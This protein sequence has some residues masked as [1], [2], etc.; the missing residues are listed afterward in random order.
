MHLDGFAIKKILEGFERERI[1]ELRLLS[2][3]WCAAI[4]RHIFSVYFVGEDVGSIQRGI[5]YR[6][7]G[8]QVQT[9]VVSG[10]IS[11][12]MEQLVRRAPAR[13]NCQQVICSVDEQ[14]QVSRL[15]EAFRSFKLLRHLTIHVLADLDF[16]LLGLFL[17][18]LT[19]YTTDDNKLLN[20]ISQF[21]S[22]YLKTFQTR[23][24]AVS[25][26]LLNTIQNNF[27]AL[28]TLTILDR[29]HLGTILVYDAKRC[30]I[31]HMGGL[32]LSFDI[33]A[34]VS[35]WPKKFKHTVFVKK[36]NQSMF[37]H[38][39]FAKATLDSLLRGRFE[40]N[41]FKEIMKVRISTT[42]ITFSGNDSVWRCL[43]HVADISISCPSIDNFP[44]PTKTFHAR[45]LKITV[46]DYLTPTFLD[47]V[48]LHFPLLKRL[49]LNPP[50]DQPPIVSSQ[51]GSFLHLEI[52]T[53]TNENFSLWDYVAARAPNILTMKAIIPT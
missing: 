32:V 38:F 35:F 52:F 39:M 36:P 53:T 40:F 49:H 12:G 46:A 7:H 11:A 8:R 44:L 20:L 26:D 50:P 13:P 9:I 34:D 21:T 33:V 43:D 4:E 28:T 25:F 18:S 29:T 19:L 31:E 24:C 37:D 23:A 30:L 15:R 27:K 17:I 1:L 22:P 48:L 51:K 45:T 10:D 2:K 47:W 16:N 5:A 14:T 3:G 42:R 41:S 6:R